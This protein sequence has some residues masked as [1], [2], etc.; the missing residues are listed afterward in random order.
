MGEH[1]RH[2]ARQLWVGLSSTTTVHPHCTPVTLPSDGVLQLADSVITLTTDV[3][4]QPECTGD[5]SG[6]MVSIAHL[7]DPFYAS[8]IPMVYVI[9]ATTVI[10]WVLVV[11][12]TIASRTSYLG[13]PHAAPAFS[14]GHGIIGGANGGNSGLS[15]AG[16]RPW[17]QK[18]AALAVAISL[19][20]ATADTLEVA[21]RQYGSGIMDAPALRREVLGSTEIRVTRVVSDI[22]LWL[23]QVQTLIRLFPR[24]KEKVMIKWIGFVLIIFDTVFSCLNSFLINGEAKGR[25]FVDAIPALSYL[26]ELALGLLYAAWV[27]YYSLTKRR[28]AFYHPKMRNILLI[29]I[30]SLVSILT[31]VVFFITD[32][33]NQDVAGWG[34]YFRWV[35]AAAASVVVW[36][37]VERIEALESDDKKDG[38]LGREVFDGDEM[39]DVVP[40]SGEEAAWT[41]SRN[42]R[43]NFRRHGRDDDGDGGGNTSSVMENGLSHVLAQRFRSKH[44]QSPQHY[45]LGRAHTASAMPH[46]E[47]GQSASHT[48]NENQQFAHIGGP[49]PPAPVASPV[50]R[51]DTTSAAST[52]Y[53][54]R[55]HPVADVPQPIR[56]RAA[57]NRSNAAKQR[58]AN[59]NSEKAYIDEGDDGED[60]SRHR[61]HSRWHAVTN[62]FKRKRTSPPQEVQRARA[63]IIDDQRAATPAHNFSRWDV[64]NRF[65]VLA[66]EAGDRIRDRNSART[67]QIEPLPVTVIPA[68]PRGNRAWTPALVEGDVPATQTPGVN[69]ETDYPP[70]SVATAAAERRANAASRNRNKE[71]GGSNQARESPPV[72]QLS[73]NGPPRAEDISPVAGRS[74]TVIVAAP[75]RYS[76]SDRENQVSVPP[77]AREAHR[78]S[79]PNG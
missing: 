26:F 1:G 28:Y 48:S 7:R 11:M 68:Q 44:Q 47:N 43:R 75:R 77:D 53:V 65:G 45:P 62:P 34:D 32:V 64:R 23:A 13:A 9:A 37:W 3:V 79:P 27:M 67:Q 57:T 15:G 40:S 39:L 2:I 61:E 35:G 56:R 74:G 51:A 46:D 6:D 29:A 8:T 33:S 70:W 18:V 22:F 50:N 30:L 58:K 41:Q 4:F 20:I 55:Y 24:H 63:D 54:V 25:N 78:N 73:R 14:N 72:L 21:Q 66:A 52:V 31:P 16:S 60:P 10:A 5:L 36:E 76:P 12:L 69:T 19:T 17:L 71:A 42:L 38:I 49:T 59:P